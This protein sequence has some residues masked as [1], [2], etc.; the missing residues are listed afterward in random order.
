MAKR[1][2]T[3]P[4]NSKTRPRKLIPT[5]SLNW[6]PRPKLWFADWELSMRNPKGKQKGS[7][8]RFPAYK[9]RTQEQHYPTCSQIAISLPPTL[10]WERDL[11]REIPTFLKTRKV[12]LRKRNYC[13]T[14]SELRPKAY[15]QEAIG[16][17]SELRQKR[18]ARHRHGQRTRIPNENI[19]WQ[20]LF[21]RTSGD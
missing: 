16:K 5:S 17:S 8:T 1:W 4:R 20:V 9:A 11:I 15:C 3:Q 6:V 18:P 12:Y 19:V 14:S 2:A 21:T 7:E 13:C 10:R